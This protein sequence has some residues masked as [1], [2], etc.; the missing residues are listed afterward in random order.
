M[1]DAREFVALCEEFLA[2]LENSP[3]NALPLMNP[4]KPR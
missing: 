3:K 1:V 2:R 4:G